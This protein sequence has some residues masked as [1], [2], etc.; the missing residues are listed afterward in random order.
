MHRR[1]NFLLFVVLAA[2]VATPAVGQA[3]TSGVGPTDS[4]TQGAALIP[5]ISGVWTHPAFPWFEPPASGPG[6]VTNRSHWPQR[7][8]NDSGTLALPPFLRA[9]KA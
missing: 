7:P 1:R 4:A 5:D 8:G 6:P 3:V 2:A 9:W